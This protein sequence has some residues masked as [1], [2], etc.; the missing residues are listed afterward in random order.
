MVQQLTSLSWLMKMV[1]ELNLPYYPLLHLFHLTPL[2]KSKKQDVRMLPVLVV[3]PEDLMVLHLPHLHSILHLP[4]LLHLGHLL[5]MVFHRYLISLA[6]FDY[7]SFNKVVFS[8]CFAY[9][10]HFSRK[11]R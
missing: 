5:H 11:F 8:N 10:S 2:N 3:V 9:L 1:T 6:K 7:F 4:D